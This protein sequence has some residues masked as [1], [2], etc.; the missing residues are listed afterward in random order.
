MRVLEARVDDIARRYATEASAALLAEAAR[1]HAALT[2]LLEHGGDDRVRRD[3]HRA[4]TVSATLLSKLIWDAS[5]RRDSAGAL[6]YCTEAASHA[7][8][9]GDVV[10]SAHTQLRR[11]YVSLYGVSQTRDP[12]AG[13]A[14]AQAAV[15]QSTGTSHALT[16]LSR[17]HVAEALAML[18]EY[19]QCEQALSAAELSL[20]QSTVDDPAALLCSPGQLGRLAGSCYLAL[21]APERA[22]PLPLRTASELQGRSKTRS[23]VL[24]NLALSHLRQRQLEAATATLHEA[25]GLPEESRGGG[26]MT[27]V[28]G[29]TRPPDCRGHRPTVRVATGAMVICGPVT[30]TSRFACRVVRP[31]LQLDPG[32]TGGSSPGGSRR[33][34]TTPGTTLDHLAEPVTGR[35]AA[36]TTRRRK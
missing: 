24:G 7:T 10:A 5:G 14:T 33:L 12:A 19:R 29:A 8:E 27:V 21:G 16:G 30:S 2:M 18:G 32:A 23:L 3:I 28:F 36:R 17:L 1:C 4:A 34:R 15:E 25:I 20:G 26:G 9:C 31:T 35:R 6:A 13:L 22:E 11:T